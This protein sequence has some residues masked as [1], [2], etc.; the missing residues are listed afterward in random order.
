MF[1]AIYK[2]RL[3]SDN[4]ITFLEDIG[5]LDLLVY[6]TNLVHNEKNPM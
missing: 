3:F 1:T 6:K 5:L 4:M 2:M